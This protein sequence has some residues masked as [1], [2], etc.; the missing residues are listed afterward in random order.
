MVEEPLKFVEQD[1]RQLDTPATAYLNG[2]RPK[3]LHF[4]MIG[5]F[6]DIHELEWPAIRGGLQSELY[7]EHDPIPVEASDLADVVAA[8][9]SD[10]VTSKLSWSISTD[11]ELARLMFSLMLI[12]PP[13]RMR[14]GFGNPRVRSR[15]RPFCHESRS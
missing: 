9:P 3:Q 11:E 1:R 14:R 8:K 10:Q 7:G 5:D 12:P 4:E 6:V 2:S 13:M 15:T